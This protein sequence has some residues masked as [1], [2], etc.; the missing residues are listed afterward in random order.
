MQAVDKLYWMKAALGTILGL[1]YGV[2][3]P[4]L[5][6]SGYTLLILGLLLNFILSDLLGKRVGVER[7]KAWKV[8][9]GAYALTWITVWV[10]I[11]TLLN[12]PP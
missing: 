5:P 12:L 1:V 9:I 3:Q 2:I 11:Y 4:Q 6:L 7:Q 10:L 8:G